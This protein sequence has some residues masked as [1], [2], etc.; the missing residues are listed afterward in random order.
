[1]GNVLKEFG[2][3]RENIVCLK[4]GRNNNMA[5]GRSPFAQR[6]MMASSHPSPHPTLQLVFDDMLG[7]AQ[8]RRDDDF[9]LK[10]LHI[11]KWLKFFHP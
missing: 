5:T 8:T 4:L 11:Q 10:Q 7:R 2:E 9:S 1:M 3:K 6:L